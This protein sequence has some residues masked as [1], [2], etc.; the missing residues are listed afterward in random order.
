MDN[1]ILYFVKATAFRDQKKTYAQKF[2][3]I[4]RVH[5]EKNEIHMLFVLY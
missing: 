4:L 5:D 3:N 2:I 1:V